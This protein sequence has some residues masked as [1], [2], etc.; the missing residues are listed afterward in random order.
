MV[1]KEVRGAWRG[2]W[3]ARR[4]GVCKESR[5]AGGQSAR[6]MFR[7]LRFPGWGRRWE[8]PRGVTPKSPLSPEPSCSPG[9]LCTAAGVK[10][11]CPVLLPGLG[12]A[13]GALLA[14]SWI[15]IFL[16]GALE[17]Q[18]RREELQ[19]W[20]G[21]SALGWGDGTAVAL[22]GSG[23]VKRGCLVDFGAGDARARS[24]KASRCLQ[25]GG[26]HPE[27]YS[28]PLPCQFGAVGP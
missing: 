20:G 16:P 27:G 24:G 21:V 23:C 26:N 1:C 25:S 19:G 11:M 8:G 10:V 17:S 9:E 12:D 13:K 22:L 14:W 2:C 15:R 18:L 3:C 4:V 28:L 6:G 7:C 5:D